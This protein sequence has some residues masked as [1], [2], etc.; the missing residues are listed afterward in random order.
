MMSGLNLELQ[1]HLCV[2]HVQGSNQFGRV[3]SGG[4]SLKVPAFMRIKHR[5]FSDEISSLRI[6]QTALLCLLTRSE[7]MCCCWHVSNTCNHVSGSCDLQMGHVM[8][9]NLSLPKNICFLAWP[10][11]VPIRNLIRHVFCL[12]VMIGFFQNSLES[13]LSISSFAVHL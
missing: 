8:D 6:S 2:P 9:G 11:Y 7:C 10:M 12:S 1:W 4:L 5:D 13:S 3:F